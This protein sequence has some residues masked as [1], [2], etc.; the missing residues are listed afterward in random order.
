MAMKK[1]GAVLRKFNYLKL[2]EVYIILLQRFMNIRE[3]RNSM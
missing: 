1:G 2:M 3:S